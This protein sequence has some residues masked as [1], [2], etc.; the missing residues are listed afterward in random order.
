MRARAYQ[1]TTD[2]SFTCLKTVLKDHPVNLGVVSAQHDESPAV[3]GVLDQDY[4]SVGTQIPKMLGR[5]SFHKMAENSFPTGI[6]PAPH[7]IVKVQS[8]ML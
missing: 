6:E 8:I 7:R 1:P 3:A 5:H 2:L 4:K